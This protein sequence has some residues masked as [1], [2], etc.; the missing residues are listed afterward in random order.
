MLGFGVYRV[1]WSLIRID[2]YCAVWNYLP[3]HPLLFDDDNSHIRDTSFLYTPSWSVVCAVD[4]YCIVSR[5]ST[6]D[7]KTFKN[8][9]EEVEPPLPQ[10]WLVISPWT[11]MISVCT[12]TI[13][14]YI[15]LMLSCVMGF[16]VQGEGGGWSYSTDFTN[17]SWR[18]EQG[19]GSKYT[20]RD[21]FLSSK[22]VIVLVIATQ[23][24]LYIVLSCS[25][26][27]RLCYNVWDILSCWP[28]N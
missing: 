4:M 11:N 5:W 21:F 19:M 2:M 1:V 12:H 17:P 8:S 28:V 20:H 14:S 3:V 16:G 22:S 10:G 27:T 9:F 6:A 25:L 18:E 15:R 26:F 24:I 7:G 23:Y 13:N